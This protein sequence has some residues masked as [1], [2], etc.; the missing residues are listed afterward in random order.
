MVPC[1]P[2]QTTG[3]GLVTRGGGDCLG[4]EG[5]LTGVCMTLRITA[6][7]RGS[8]K[9]RACSP[10]LSSC[11]WSWAPRGVREGLSCFPRQGQG[12]PRAQMR[13]LPAAPGAG[14]GLQHQPEGKGPPGASGAVGEPTPYLR[15]HW[16]WESGP[17][18]DWPPSPRRAG[19]EAPRADVRPGEGDAP[20]VPSPT[21]PAP[22][23][24]RSGHRV[25][26]QA[27]ERV[28]V[29]APDTGPSFLFLGKE[30]A[31]P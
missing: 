10:A 19:P 18:A 30:G 26:L 1:T 24:R 5:S 17:G 21:P 14:Q 13:V 11:S 28:G 25:E 8:L 27:T 3:T 29:E 2:L 22:V 7:P 16:A 6:F 31:A 20:P 23:A 12:G 15:P 4:G 9:T